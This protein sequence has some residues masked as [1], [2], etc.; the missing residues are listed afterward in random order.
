MSSNRRAPSP[1]ISGKNC[2]DPILD[3]KDVDNLKRFL[4]AHGQL[5][6]RK[7]TG[8]CAQ[9]QKALKQAVKRARHLSLLPFVG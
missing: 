6:S 4:T 5:L 9:C 7:R 2:D 8:Y 3:Y 1:P